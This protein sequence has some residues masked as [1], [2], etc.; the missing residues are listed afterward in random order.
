[1]SIYIYFLIAT[2]IL[3]ILFKLLLDTRKNN[4]LSLLYPNQE[5]FQNYKQEKIPKLIIQTWKDHHIPKKY[6]YDVHSVKM[7]NPDFKRLFFTDNDIEDFLKKNYP[8]YYLTYLKLPVLIQKIDFFRYI[9]V[10]HFGGFYYDLDM[11]ATYPLNDLVYFDA[12]FPI[13]QVRGSCRKL[14]WKTLCN[15]KVPIVLGNYAFGASPKNPFLKICI[16]NIHYNI[17]KLIETQNKTNNYVYSTTGPDYI[18]VL[19]HKYPYKNT[20]K[21]LENPK[22]TKDHVFGKYAK[23]NFY[24][25]WKKKR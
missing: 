21:L 14:R 19:Y 2:C 13:E 7:V 18:S 22:S 10:Y 6:D 24:G 15:Q 12:V 25:T 3:L 4:H 9:A 8:D 17:D 1:M 20:I 23:H 16:D 11:S 5:Y